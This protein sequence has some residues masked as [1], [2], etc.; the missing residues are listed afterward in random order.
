M[1]AMEAQTQ[2][3]DCT[4]S[5]RPGAGPEAGASP[6]RAPPVGYLRVLAQ[7]N[8]E[9]QDWPLGEGQAVGGYIL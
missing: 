3:V 7:K 5:G 4:G 2:V 9:E 6:I 1:C 8:L